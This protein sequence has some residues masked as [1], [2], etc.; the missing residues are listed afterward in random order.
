MFHVSEKNWQPGDVITPGNF[1]ADIIQNSRPDFVITANNL[2]IG[3]F[4]RN[5]MWEAALE[6]AKPTLAPDAPSRGS[7]VFLSETLDLARRFR[8]RFKNGHSI[9]E[10]KVV[11]TDARSHRGD[12]AV[13]ENVPEPLYRALP[14]RSRQYWTNPEPLFPELLW[15]GA[16]TVVRKLE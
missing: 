10:V 16:V 5:F 12:F 3:K 14:E 9:F 2:E 11:D 8:D 1:G 6:T 15:E 7:V 4:V 13:F